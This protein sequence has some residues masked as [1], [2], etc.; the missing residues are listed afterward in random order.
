MSDEV[1]IVEILGERDRL[2]DE[3]RRFS[4]RFAESLGWFESGNWAA[5]AEGFGK[6]SAD[7]PASGPAAYLRDVSLR[8]LANP[9]PNASPVIR[10][11]GK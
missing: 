5:A 4:E 3:A 6:L 8:Y 9:P 2:T 10:V 11:V 7:E 1:D